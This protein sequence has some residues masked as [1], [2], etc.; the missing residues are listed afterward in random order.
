[1]SR[2]LTSSCSTACETANARGKRIILECEA[3]DAFVPRSPTRRTSLVFGGESK[4]FRGECLSKGRVAHHTLGSPPSQTVGRH[5]LALGWHIETALHV[6]RIIL[7]GTFDRHPR[8]QL[9]VGHMG[10]TLPFMLQRLDVMPMAM[11]KLNRS[12]S[13]YLRENIHYTFSGFN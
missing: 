9:L 12:I 2:P 11:T 1:M 5:R 10:E 4:W 8:L 3:E 6:I 7:G 13:S